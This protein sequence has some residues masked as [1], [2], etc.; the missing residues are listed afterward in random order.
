MPTQRLRG[1]GAQ[2][3]V[4]YVLAPSPAPPAVLQAVTT[5]AQKEKGQEN[6]YSRQQ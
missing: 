4:I 6:I 2:G 1:A 5:A 3:R